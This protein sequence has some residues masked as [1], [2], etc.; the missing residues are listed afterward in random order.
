[1]ALQ[2]GHFCREVIQSRA[3]ATLAIGLQLGERGERVSA[4]G[5]ECPDYLSGMGYPI[6][7]IEAPAAVVVG[8]EG[9]GDCGHDGNR[10]TGQ[11]IAAFLTLE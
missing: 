9:D 8:G 2:V 4:G 7:R 6:E 11:Q 10:E 1:M 3:I 5:I